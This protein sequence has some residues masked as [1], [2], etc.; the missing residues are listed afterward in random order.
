MPMLK[1]CSYVVVQFCWFL[2]LQCLYYSCPLYDYAVVRILRVQT[3][4]GVLPR[5]APC[6]VSKDEPRPF[7]FVFYGPK[8][9][10]SPRSIVGV[11]FGG[12]AHFVL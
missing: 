4:P 5:D 9:K 10:V 2:H 12:F 8:V 7:V 3:G 1:P 6:T 11:I